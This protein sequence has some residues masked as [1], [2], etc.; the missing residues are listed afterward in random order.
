[1]EA[2]DRYCG[3]GSETTAARQQQVTYRCTQLYNSDTIYTPWCVTDS[4]YIFS[5][6]IERA[7]AIALAIFSVRFTTVINHISCA[8]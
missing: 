3:Q 8:D 5:S 4:D 7:P 2:N 1:M 6:F